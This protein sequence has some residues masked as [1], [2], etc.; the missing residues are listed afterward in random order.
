MAM[1]TWIA[2]LLLAGTAGS[3]EAQTN[4][5]AVRI[6][7]VANDPVAMTA[8]DLLTVE[9]SKR[10]SLQLLERAEIQRV[11][12]EQGWS[13]ANRDYLKLGQV[14][15]ADGLLVLETAQEGTNQV[16]SARL[17][18]ARPG[19]VIAGVRTP[20]PND[21]PPQWAK[22]L[23]QDFERL[24]PKLCVLPKDAVPISVLNLRSAL[25]TT[26]DRSLEKELTVL[27]IHR[28][29]REREVFVLERQRL[30]DALFEKQ[31]GPE[32]DSP[33]W[34]GRF[35][36]DGVLDREGFD[37]NKLTIH[38][39]LVAPAGGKTTPMQVTGPR[40]N[41][42][43]LVESLVNQVLSMTH[44][45]ATTTEWRPMEEAEQYYSEAQWALRW[46][47]KAEAQAASES[48]WALGKR[49]P[50]VAAL[51]VRCYMDGIPTIFWASLGGLPPMPDTTK[52]A[53]A[54]RALELFSED[55]VRFG[56]TN[57]PADA[58]WLRI[59]F[60][61][62]DLTSGLLENFHRLV[63]AQAGLE[64]P[65]D[66]LRFQAR[67][68]A[69]LIP[70]NLTNGVAHSDPARGRNVPQP[71]QKF[72]WNWGGLWHDKLDDA[73]PM[74][75]QILEGGWRPSA[76]M[77]LTAWSW[78][79]R[80][81]IPSL[82]RQ[83]VHGVCQSTND[84]L[85]LD[86]LLW[87]AQLEPPGPNGDLDNR[88]QA[89]STAVWE[90]RLRIFTGE[91]DG[92]V[93]LRMEDF[94]RSQTD[95]GLTNRVAE[96]M[97][98]LRR[99]YLL[100]TPSFNPT[101]FVALFTQIHGS[102]HYSEEHARQLMPLLTA[103][104]VRLQIK[105]P[106]DYPVQT[107][108]STVSECL[109]NASTPAVPARP[110][111]DYPAESPIGV[112]DE[113]Y[114]V[115]MVPLR[116]PDSFQDFDPVWQPI[117]FISYRS[118]QLWLLVYRHDPTTKARVVGPEAAF[119]RV[120]LDAGRQEVVLVPAEFGRP[121][122][123]FEVT[124]DSL[125][126]TA[127]NRVLRYRLKDKQWETFGT[128]IQD[129]A[130]ITQLDGRFYLTTQDSI[131]ELQPEAKTT[132]VM[133]SARRRPAL[134][135]LDR[136]GAVGA[137]GYPAVFSA[138][139][140]KIGVVVQDRLFTHLAGSPEWEDYELPPFGGKCSIRP[141]VGADGVLLAVTCFMMRDRW[142]EWNRA[143]SDFDPI[144]E[145]RSPSYDHDLRADKVL[146]PPRWL[147]PNAFPLA[148]GIAC[149][150]RQS[151]WVPVPR[152]WSPQVERN[153]EIPL[154]RFEPEFR[155]AMGIR[156]RFM[157]ESRPHD[158][159]RRSY[160]TATTGTGSVEL[161]ALAT[162]AGL[163]VVDISPYPT[164]DPPGYW[165]V[166]R[167]VLEQRLDRLR[168]RLRAKADAER[169]WQAGLLARFD[170][171][172]NGEMDPEEITLMHL[173]PD[174][175]EHDRAR[176]DLDASGLL[177]VEELAYFDANRNGIIETSERQAIRLFHELLARQ[178]MAAPDK[179]HSQGLK[180]EVWQAF[181]RKIRLFARHRMRKT[182]E[183]DEVN[184]AAFESFDHDRNGELGL[185]ELIGFFEQRFSAIELADYGYVLAADAQR[186]R[187]L[188]APA[189]VAPRPTGDL[190]P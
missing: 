6:A 48:A 113:P 190:R 121:F 107:A 91:L 26:L 188:D 64:M 70:N 112:A 28:L 171:N 181:A 123:A 49:T 42:I 117:G 82:R 163:V 78:A 145:H 150:D 21:D 118:G 109:P 19:V 56:S 143:T 178:M 71:W 176:I 10:E 7:L 126:A 13:A 29:T 59:G 38:A 84:S 162:R 114:T 46:G 76:L 5:G 73:I 160:T 170:A 95:S 47:L 57:L 189:K 148:D 104:T 141:T 93:V 8:A 131:L 63:E 111:P 110:V 79:D 45:N 187:Q 77:R 133:A 146:P 174:C 135:Q 18:A 96:F 22:W 99:D 159:T 85:R 23:A 50:E 97:M 101:G 140:G 157:G 167:F 52:I 44:R 36:L 180:P 132:R 142:L 128:P 164:G 27:L 105:P 127:A 54:T 144:L 16:L 24:Y 179:Q 51:R 122:G 125:Y 72:K 87:A 31:I 151:L 108:I 61:A 62:L 98:R 66:Q 115:P 175:L 35:L 60:D 32:E 30:A 58:A 173:A 20:W 138:P 2:L 165:L 86:G 119:V 90:Q 81:R 156:A 53:S 39:R 33:F 100:N 169:V 137:Y 120:D 9:L 116:L 3:V 55:T 182:P 185:V 43:P 34:T 75:G 41:L 40:T 147:W 172:K 94:V 130:R 154:F 102:K 161:A 186:P 12:R 37:P 168:P 183:T 17:V 106:G 65:L 149:P 15:S 1:N 92:S 69:A 152:L 153:C 89:L 4:F 134:N 158:M 11:F 88:V 129:G 184:A 74:Y 68:A 103:F 80:K 155:E 177:D 67:Q 124:E 139:A 83:F 136:V 25:R 166:P 14:L